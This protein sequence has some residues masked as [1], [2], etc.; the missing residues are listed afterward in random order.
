MLG[1]QVSTTTLGFLVIFKSV[2]FHS[3]YSFGYLQP[4]L[5]HMT[6]SALH[7][8]YLLN[9]GDFT[10]AHATGYEDH[11]EI[12]VYEVLRTAAGLSQAC[13]GLTVRWL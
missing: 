5:R 8:L 9:R 12:H 10:Q 13:I 4:M 7:F 11:M 6:F 1:L 2:K 3:K